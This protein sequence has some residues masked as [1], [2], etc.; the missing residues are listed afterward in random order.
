MNHDTPV[1]RIRTGARLH[2]GLFSDPQPG[3]KLHQGFGFMIDQ[4]SVNLQAHVSSDAEVKY[5]SNVENTLGNHC[6]NILSRIQS[7]LQKC[8]TNWSEVRQQLRI[9]VHEII[10]PHIGL[11][12]GTQLDLATAFLWTKL[13]DIECSP[14]DLAQVINR[15]KRS[16]IGTYGFILGGIL[17]DE[18]IKQ[19]E[20]LGRCRFRMDLPADW[21]FVL[22]TPR[23]LFGY[24]GAEELQAFDKLTSIS[25]R[26][27]QTL[28]NYL[29]IIENQTNDFDVLSETLREYGNLIGDTF[30]QV[31]GGRYRDPICQQIYDVMF[32]NGIRGIAQTSWGPTMFGLCE[33]QEQAGEISQILRESFSDIEISIARPMNSGAIA[34]WVQ[35]G[36]EKTEPVGRLI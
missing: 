16:T 28:E 30:S 32:A 36:E 8:E 13:A 23:K 26:D 10:L 3:G 29:Q 5:Q 22:A 7:T 4:P 27:L 33:N 11:G 24:S 25:E 21:R 35:P 19:E 6:D 14:L 17:I 12:S 34:E 9:T 2:C 15:G 18:G 20:E 1:L 31:Q